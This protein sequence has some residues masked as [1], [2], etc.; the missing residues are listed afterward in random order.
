MEERN[1]KE[2]RYDFSGKTALI[3]GGA[4]GIGRVIALAFARQGASV[5]AHGFR[6]SRQEGGTGNP[7]H[8]P[9][10]TDHNAKGRIV[11]TGSARRGS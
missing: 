4:A 5:I 2:P 1:R 6:P 10:C 11:Q 3:T 7:F 8:G 9:G